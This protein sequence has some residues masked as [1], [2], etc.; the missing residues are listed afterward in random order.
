MS[1]VCI[2]C[3]VPDNICD[4]HA[5]CVEDVWAAAIKESTKTV[6]PKRAKQQPQPKTVR[7]SCRTCDGSDCSKVIWGC[8]G[9]CN[10]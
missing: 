5:D 4:A 10:K 6:C 7:L 2:G 1:K 3:K 9:K 8:V